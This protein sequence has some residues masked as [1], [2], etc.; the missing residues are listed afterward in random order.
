MKTIEE[1]AFE[2]SY[3][4]PRCFLNLQQTLEEAYKQGA[5]EQKK[6]DIDESCGWLN[7][8]LKEYFIQSTR[9]IV[10]EAKSRQ[11]IINDI[12][13]DFRKAIEEQL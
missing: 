5:T 9:T 4:E 13:N 3:A 8:N 6:I 12:I 10:G 2:Y 11:E 1:R 7:K